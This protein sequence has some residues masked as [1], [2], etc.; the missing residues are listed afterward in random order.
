MFSCLL[1]LFPVYCCCCF[2]VYCCHISCLHIFLFLFQEQELYKRESLG[3]TEVTY[4]DNQDCIGQPS[5]LGI[6]EMRNAIPECAAYSLETCNVWNEHIHVIIHVRTYMYNFFQYTHLLS[7]SHSLPPVLPTSL[8]PSLPS[9]LSPPS[10]SLFLPS[11]L[12]P[13]PDLIEAKKMGII[14]LLDEECKLPKGTALHFTD[15]VHTGHKDHFR[16]AV[17]RYMY[18]YI[19]RVL[20]EQ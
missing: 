1:L 10:L 7:L 19:C 12:L 16:L 20:P 11:F 8:P 4:M 3:V 2:P 13:S 17:S 18:M 5:F 15:C 14:D 6:P 9:S